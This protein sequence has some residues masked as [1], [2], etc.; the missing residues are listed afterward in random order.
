MYPPLIPVVVTQNY[1]GEEGARRRGD[2]ISVSAARA[3]YLIE[4]G[5][6]T[7]DKPGPQ[8]NTMAN[9]GTEKKKPSGVATPGRLTA[10][11][12]SSAPGP[13]APASSSPAVQASALV[14][15]TQSA[16]P[17]KA[18]PNVFRR[19]RGSQAG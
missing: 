2:R 17:E 9:G 18:A 10:T 12:S 1:I 6:A 7:L 13:A 11:P 14:K 4:L 16:Q 3:R 5:N 19:R 8:A 15:P